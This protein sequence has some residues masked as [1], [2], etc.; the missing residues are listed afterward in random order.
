MVN[1]WSVIGQIIGGECPL[2]HQPGNRLCAPCT[3][4]LPY[5]RKPCSRCALPLPDAAPDPV[6][7][8]GC[9][10]NAPAFDRVLAPLLY[11]APVDDLVAGFKYHHRLNLGPVLAEVL[12]LAVREQGGRAQLLLPVPMPAQGLRERGFNQAAELARRLSSQLGIPWAG[13]RLIRVHENRHQQSLG[14]SQRRR[15]VRGV[16]ECRGTLPGQVA[17]IDDVMTTGATAGEAC[18]MLKGAGADRV[19]VWTVARTPREHW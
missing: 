3:Q 12:A 17:L 13:D 11:R 14:R 18:R 19:E 4:A 10:A 1:M 7:C 2:C 16:F 9:Q 15:N 6:L 5:N 8:A